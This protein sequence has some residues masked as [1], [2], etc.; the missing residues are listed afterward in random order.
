MTDLA[1]KLRKHTQGEV[2]F[3]DADRARY[4]TDASIYQQIP[5]G[6]FVPKSADDVKAAIDIA[7]DLKAPVLPRGGGTSQ[8]G[9]TTGV[10][11]VID[12]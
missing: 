7:R 1:T 12:T 6:V 3:T 4:A 11:L 2:L 10:A 9:Q 8:C 5:L